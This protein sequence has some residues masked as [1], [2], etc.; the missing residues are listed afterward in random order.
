MVGSTKSRILDEVFHGDLDA[1]EAAAV[2]SYDFTGLEDFGKVLND[3]L[4]TWFADED[5]LRL[6]REL[7]MEM[8][9]EKKETTMETGSTFPENPFRGRTIV[10]T[11]KLEHFTRDGINDKI[12]ELSGKPGSSVSKKTDYLI[13]GEKP[14]ASLPKHSS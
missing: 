13:C 8:N 10:A 12:L 6:W 11:G 3:N 7:Q 5:N 4:H 9:F 2:G 14:E 1:L